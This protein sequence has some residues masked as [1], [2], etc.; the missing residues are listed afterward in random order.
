MHAPSQRPSL[1]APPERVDIHDD[2]CVQNMLDSL[3]IAGG[4]YPVVMVCAGMNRTFNAA[5]G[6]CM[7]GHVKEMGAEGRLVA[8]VDDE[9]VWPERSRILRQMSLQDRIDNCRTVTRG[10]VMDAVRSLRDMEAELDRF[11]G[12]LDIL[13]QPLCNSYM[14]QYWAIVPPDPALALPEETTHIVTPVGCEP[15]QRRMRLAAKDALAGGG[16]CG[17]LEAVALLRHADIN[18]ADERTSLAV[19]RVLRAVLGKKRYRDVCVGQGFVG[20]QYKKVQ[21]WKI[22]RGERQRQYT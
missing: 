16:E 20:R 18:A 3:G 7:A 9:E 22:R 12:V 14:E 15:L 11:D 5:V 21:D 6:V 1:S 13:L 17:W 2:A 4:S 8:R 19:T 10:A